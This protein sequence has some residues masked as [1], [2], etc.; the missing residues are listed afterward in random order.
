METDRP[1][2]MGMDR[3]GADDDSLLEPHEDTRLVPGLVEVALGMIC[4]G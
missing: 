3:P 4:S 2:P 1:G